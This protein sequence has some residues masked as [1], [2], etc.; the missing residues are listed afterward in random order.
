MDNN[1]TTES[2]WNQFN[3][4]DTSLQWRETIEEL[5]LSTISIPGLNGCI[6]TI[7]GVSNNKKFFDLRVPGSDFLHYIVGNRYIFSED[8]EDYEDIQA[9]GFYTVEQYLNI[10]ETDV[11][12]SLVF[13]INDPE[14]GL[15]EGIDEE[16]IEPNHV[17]E[18]LQYA[19]LQAEIQQGKI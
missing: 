5:D 4:G 9:D 3:Q 2:E 12:K 14:E 18:R 16:D 6:Q 19:K 7:V 11:T 8:F 15:Y 10:N 13:L 1:A 17:I